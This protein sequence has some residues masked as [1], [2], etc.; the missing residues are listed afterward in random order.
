[1]HYFRYVSGELYCEGVP[2]RK[3]A[4]EVGTPAYIYSK[5]TLERHFKAFDESFQNVDH[6]VF[7]V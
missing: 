1:M 2:L 3:L 4:D 5:A 7:S 6:L